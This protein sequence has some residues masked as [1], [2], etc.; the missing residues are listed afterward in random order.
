MRVL[1]FSVCLALKAQTSAGG[2]APA[3]APPA[4]AP[5][6][7]APA[8]APPAPAPA[9]PAPATA[10]PPPAPAPPAPS[11]ATAATTTPAPAAVSPAAFADP[12]STTFPHD[13]KTPPPG[14]DTSVEEPPTTWHGYETHFAAEFGGRALSNSGN[15][16][17]Y[18]TFVNLQPGERLMDQS[19]EMHSINHTGLLFDD[20]SESAFG[21]G[22]DP[23]EVVRVRASKN[24]WYDFSG[25][26][27]RDINFWDYNLLGNPL[28][29]PAGTSSVPINVSPNLLDLSRKML[30]L[31]LTL[32]PNSKV[33]FLLGYSHYN[34]GGP[35]LT[36][37]HEGTE[38]ELDQPWRDISDSY[39][40]GI[41][42]TPADRTRI[43][44]DQ[45]YSH[46]KS[47]TS[48][49]LSSSSN[50]LS[51]GTPANLGISFG[52][53]SPCATPLIGSS[54]NPT[55]NLFTSYSNV[56][57]YYTNIPTEQF[58][59]QSNYFRRLHVTGRA[60]YTGAQTHLPNSTE[61]FAGYDSR[62]G[63]TQATITG[64][65]TARQI[66]T[67]ADV[68]VTYEITERFSVDDQFRWYDYRI[69]SAAAF[70]ENDLYSA[71][72]LSGGNTYSAS[73][74]PPPYTSPLCPQHTAANGAD[75]TSTAYSLFQAQNQKRNTFKLHYDFATHFTGYIGYR[76]ERQDIRVDGTTSALATYFPT[77]ATRGCS[78][79]VNGVCQASTSSIDTASVQ[80]NTH[81][82][83]LGLAAE[84]IHGL[85]LNAD[86]E[87]AY[88]DNVFTDIM[89]RRMQLYRG[90]AIY[91]PKKWLDLN[92]NVQIQE[93]RDL[94]YG[95]GNLQHNRTFSVGAILP[96]SARVGLD[97]HYSYNNF[98]SNLNI[99]FSETPTP[100]YAA[101]TALC[102]VGY[103]TT[104][105]YYRNA[106]QFGSANLM[107]KPL[108][109]TTVTAGY[110]LTSTTGS[111]LQL[112]P[113][114]PL[115]PIAVNYHL[116]SAA[117]ALAVSSSVTF[118]AGWNF[119][120]Y[121]EKS[122]PGI[123]APRNFR[124]N[125]ISVS[126]RYAR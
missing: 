10:P 124:A 94:A 101:T 84:P 46:N 11:A 43:S 66:T 81:A 1:G 20:F 117:L 21:L 73:T 114:A 119:Y 2:Q 99:C 49:F 9:P 55:C 68:G 69:P 38:A 123:V 8:P 4:P 76:F 44:Y 108:R 19:L 5:A 27:R 51:N 35:S 71:S 52:N 86:M 121:D 48:D 93:E 92:A 125:L 25:S 105:S 120:D 17:V 41:A 47:D 63:E 87:I 82:G 98:L 107:F 80:I 70:L 89:P 118:K 61:A 45:F 28:N 104:L 111:N 14:D 77:L 58:G 88:A 110:T 40:F 34:N 113:L 13:S 42:W 6:P 26:W 75:Q 57:P 18:A 102:G 64:A 95:L 122:N 83:L 90:K 116:P 60:S 103:L 24:H 32:L 79:P 109:R 91:S 39:H 3:P 33:Q 65:G 85:R 53:G 30:D 37:V 74:C 16:D 96:F 97:F 22:G 56:A 31:N 112:N 126:L 106:D 62:V 67:S 50:S 72:A 36:T 12:S 15:A 54:V 78:S 59:F 23:N 100:V 7:P 115:G 29:P